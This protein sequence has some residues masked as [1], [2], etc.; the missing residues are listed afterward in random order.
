MALRLTVPATVAVITTADAK[1]HLRESL[2]DAGNDAYIAALVAVATQAAEHRLGR[3]LM[4]QTWEL[5]LD[6]FPSAI[7]LDNAP[8]LGVTSVEYRQNDADGDYVVLSS[9]AYTADTASEPGYIVPAYGYTWPTPRDEINAVRVTYTAGYSASATVATAQAA[10]PVA[11]RQWIL[12]AV[13]DMYAQR[14]ASNARPVVRH[15]FVDSLLD[16]YRIWGV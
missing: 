16:R 8:I 2:S 3:S 5:T 15:D 12:L 13:G 4:K 7:R 9:D 6:R 10:V 11:I 1:T 14:A